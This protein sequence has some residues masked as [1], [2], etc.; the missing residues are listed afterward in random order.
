MADLLWDETYWDTFGSDT[1][2]F[3]VDRWQG[4]GERSNII[5]IDVKATSTDDSG[6]LAGVDAVLLG[7]NVLFVSDK[8]AQ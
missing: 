2:R 4:A 7:V 1:D 8:N 6:T 3:V 5:S